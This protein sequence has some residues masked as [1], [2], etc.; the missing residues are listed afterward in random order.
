MKFII[1]TENKKRD[2]EL[3]LI[4][5]SVVEVYLDDKWIDSI[6]SEE[7]FIHIRRGNKIASSNGILVNA[8][9]VEVKEENIYFY[10]KKENIILKQPEKTSDYIPWLDIGKY[11]VTEKDMDFDDYFRKFVIK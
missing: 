10:T 8:E 4:E 7:Q 6:Y 5:K 11:Y 3:P 2:K 9:R 1:E